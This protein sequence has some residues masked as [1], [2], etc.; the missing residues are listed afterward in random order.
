VVE[1]DVEEALDLRA[2][3]VHGHHPVR[4]GHR[5]QVRR[6]LRRDRHARLVLAILALVAV[7]RHTAVTR[8]ADARRQASSMTRSDIMF[9]AGGIVG[10]TTNTSSPRMFSSILTWISPSS[11]LPDRRLPTRRPTARRCAAPARD[12]PF[13]SGS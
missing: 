6:E 5:D 11:K 12:S 3:Q 2:M 8:R 9:S 13:P 10:C 4:A 1:R 7:V